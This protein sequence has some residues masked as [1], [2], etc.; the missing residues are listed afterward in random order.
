MNA[1]SRGS[2]GHR[3]GFVVVARRGSRGV[4]PWTSR[5]GTD[6]P[7][8][9][10][11]C[12]AVTGPDA[13]P[14]TS[15]T[16][17]WWPCC[18]RAARHWMHWSARSMHGWAGTGFRAA[19]HRRIAFGIEAPTPRQRSGRARC[20]RAP[21]TRTRCCRANRW[22]HRGGRGWRQPGQCR[23]RGHAVSTPAGATAPVPARQHHGR[24]AVPAGGMREGRPFRSG[25]PARLSGFAAAPGRSAGIVRGTSG[26][27]TDPRIRAGRISRARPARARNPRG[28]HLP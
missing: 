21:G 5:S 2:A 22:R 13:A 15:S 18:R 26:Q 23:R 3:A 9:H 12:H 20:P 6:F 1:M 17:G 16:P 25:L 19:F 27:F 28:S 14:R 8:A 4:R 11:T 10:W 7:P 24:A